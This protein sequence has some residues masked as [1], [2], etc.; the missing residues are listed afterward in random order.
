MRGQP[1]R[2]AAET[3][4]PFSGSAIDRS[5]PLQFRLDGRLINGFAG[6]TV[7]SAAIAAGIDTLGRRSGG[8]V[9]LSTRCAPAIIA[10]P[11]RKSVV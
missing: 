3:S 7:L 1:N 4:G 10:V 8:A 6:D 9:A 5:Q 2:L 11:D